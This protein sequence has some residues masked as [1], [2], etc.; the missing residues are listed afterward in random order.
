MKRHCTGLDGLTGLTAQPRLDAAAQDELRGHMLGCYKYRRFTDMTVRC[1]ADAF[2]LHRIVASRSRYFSAL[3]NRTDEAHHTSL[4]LY[5]TDPRMVRATI[6]WLYTCDIG[7]P[8]TAEALMLLEASRFFQVEGM[9][10]QCVERL[11]R[12]IKPD[13]AILAWEHAHRIG[14]DAACDAALGVMGPALPRLALTPAFLELPLGSVL[15][16]LHSESLELNCE[17]DAYHAAMVW[18]RHSEPRCADIGSLFGAVN[19]GRLPLDFLLDIVSADAVAANDNV[20]YQAFAKTVR[21]RGYQVARRRKYVLKG[22]LVLVGCD[23]LQPTALIYDPETGRRSNLPL[24]LLARRGCRAVLINGSLCVFGGET[25]DCISRSGERFYAQDRIWR[26]TRPMPHA[27]RDFAAAVQDG[28][29]Y[30]AGGRDEESDLR[31]ASAYD[32]ATSEWRQLAPMKYLGGCAAV[33]VGDRVLVFG[34][35][36]P[37]AEALSISTATWS[38]LPPSDIKR[39]CVSAVLHDGLVYVLGGYGDHDGAA[40]AGVAL[41]VAEVYDPVTNTWSR[42]ADMGLA[43]EA[44]C[45]ASYSGFI[46]ALGGSEPDGGDDLACAERYCPIKR[47][48]ERLMDMP[49]GFGGAGL[50]SL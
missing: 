35:T 47:Q 40:Q 7:T 6:E 4:V 25:H 5:E 14:C 45:V 9:E 24:P 18:M 31:Y 20:A 41:A 30:E 50:V 8:G 49:H 38:D 48:W 2:Q 16:I 17:Q 28:V 39:T 42:I 1:G 44:P 10:H 29:L 32:I 12:C 19:M 15:A 27:K 13:E 46:Y 33:C 22:A 37:C 36:G 11:A 3:L 34:S 21:D 26:L 43:R 23:S